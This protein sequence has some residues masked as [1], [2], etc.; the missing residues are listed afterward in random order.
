MNSNSISANQFARYSLDDWLVHIQSQHWRSVDL[1]LDRVAEVWRR[2][3]L[4]YGDD[5]VVI[6]VA[7]TNGKGSCVAMLDAVFR[8]AGYRVGAYTSPHLV[9]FNERIL[10]DGLAVADA[11]LCAAFLEIEGA[12]R[13]GKKKIPLTYF[14]FGTLCA[15]LIFRQ[16]EVAVSVLEAGMGGRL[17]AV[18]IVA[19]DLALITSIG[20][21][22]AAWLGENREQI[23]AEK[24]GILKRGA[25][26]VCSDAAPPTC[27]A[28]IAAERDCAMLQSG[29]D[30]EIADA[31]DGLRWRSNHAA[32]GDQWRCISGLRAPLFGNAQMHNLGGVVATVA[33]LSARLDVTPKHLRDGL[34]DTKLAARCQVI[35]SAPEVVL[36]VAHN[37]DSARDLAAFLATRK[38][39]CGGVTHGVFGVLADKPVGEIAA[40]MS[41]EIDRWYVATLAGERGQNADEVA[42]ALTETLPKSSSVSRHESP[43]VAW[44]A[45]SAAAKSAD[46]I[47]VF[48]S[49]YTVGDIIKILANADN[50]GD[51]FALNSR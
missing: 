9:R 28:R 6:A 51:K 15:L 12:R 38:L 25:V 8:A 2:L 14:E 19:N 31:D 20:V 46:R 29:A 43:A 42:Q 49:F 47:V 50:G 4:D 33:V 45:A 3:S 26:A 44:Q 18:N 13:K 39:I 5:G 7:G 23:G 27:I 11:D 21:D 34:A 1:S 36:D 16:T 48:G 17:D 35:S 10:V 40:V 22:H 32:I 41:G 37:A 30:Y 24:A